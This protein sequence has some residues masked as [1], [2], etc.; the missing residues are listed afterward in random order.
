MPEENQGNRLTFSMFME[1]MWMDTEQKT[2]IRSH[3]E[4]DP[5]KSQM[6]PIRAQLEKSG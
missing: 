4:W 5:V 2:D 3:P 1:I 6:N